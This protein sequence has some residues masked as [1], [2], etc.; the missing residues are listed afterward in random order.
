M[1]PSKNDS[2]KIE[3]L[4]F[5]AEAMIVFF[6][7]KALSVLKRKGKEPPSGMP[8]FVPLDEENKKNFGHPISGLMTKVIWKREIS[9]AELSAQGQLNG[10]D[11]FIDRVKREFADN[12]GVDVDKVVVEFRIIA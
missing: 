11:S 12:N 3:V 8:I 4:T 1:V 10:I 5:Y 6:F 9:A 2:E 7:D